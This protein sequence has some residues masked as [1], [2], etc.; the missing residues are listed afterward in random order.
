M[1][2]EQCF[3]CKRTQKDIDGIFADILVPFRKNVED[4]D[5]RKEKIIKDYTKQFKKFSKKH[6]GK[7]YLDLTFQTIRTDKEQFSR[8]I[9]G[10]DEFFTYGHWK[11]LKLE[12]KDK[13]SDMIDYVMDDKFF[14]INLKHRYLS[15]DPRV[16]IKEIML[17]RNGWQR[18]VERFEL[19][20]YDMKLFL[21]MDFDYLDKDRKEEMEEYLLDKRYHAIICPVCKDMIHR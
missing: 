14:E 21:K 11:N 10:L 12:T 3:V 6:K 8:M 5:K 17:E 15:D 2:E 13:L 9:D 4:L 1:T 18:L 19:S 20:T 16:E 7:D